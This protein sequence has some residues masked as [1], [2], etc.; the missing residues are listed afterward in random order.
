MIGRHNCPAKWWRGALREIGSKSLLRWRGGAR[1]SLKQT[2]SEVQ[3]QHG[4]DRGPH[5]RDTEW[6]ADQAD[7]Q[8][9][10]ERSLNGKAEAYSREPKQRTM[11]LGHIR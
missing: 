8:I 9:G 6:R 5:K 7:G 2:T 10:V 11:R 1:E 3:H 4:C